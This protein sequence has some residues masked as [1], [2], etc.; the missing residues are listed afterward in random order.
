MSG[1]RVKVAVVSE[2]TLLLDRGHRWPLLDGLDVRGVKYAPDREAFTESLQGCAAIVAGP[3]PYDRAVLAALPDLEVICRSGVGCDQI[4][5]GAAEDLGILVTTTPGLTTHTVA[6]HAL[7]LL[8]A[9]LHR[10]P[11]S[12]AAVRAGG[13]R[14]TG[15]FH[16]LRSMSVGVVGFGAIGRR[17]AELVVPFGA[18]VRAFD[19]QGSTSAS[20][21]ILQTDSLEELL[22]S[23]NVLSLHVPLTAST[24]HLIGHQELALME[25][26]SYIVNTARGGVLDES[27][28]VEA[29][30]SGQIAGAALDVFSQ[31]PLDPHSRLRDLPN[32]ILTPHN[33]SFGVGAIRGVSEMICGQL[34][35]VI[36]HRLPAGAVN[37]PPAPRLLKVESR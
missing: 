16:E 21:G 13:W 14:D 27:A 18:R 37:D 36:N 28:L 22:S 32:C 19:T 7:G 6:E 24:R 5:I 8:L 1:R 11:A 12:D 9:L 34:E 4:D 29:M 15:L 25:P 17:F 35:M 10:I 31:E 3:E 23:S 26:G 20:H 30:E 2:A 33:S